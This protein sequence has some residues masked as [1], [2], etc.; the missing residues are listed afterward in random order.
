[1]DNLAVFLS[2]IFAYL[3]RFNFVFEDF[4]IVIV[5]NH[6]LITLGIYAIFSLIFKSYSGLLRHSTIIDI[7]N[8]LIATSFSFI[9]LVFLSLLARLIGMNENLV[10]SLSIIMIHYV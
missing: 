10:I 1:M 5:I 2:F 6:A 8:V 9:T 4:S 7:L 3:L